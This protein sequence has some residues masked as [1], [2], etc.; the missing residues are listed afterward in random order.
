MSAQAHQFGTAPLGH[1]DGLA[2]QGTGLF[3]RHRRHLPRRTRHHDHVTADLAPGGRRGQFDRGD[4]KRIKQ[5]VEAFLEQLQGTAR[6]MTEAFIELGVVLQFQ[7]MQDKGEVIVGDRLVEARHMQGQATGAWETGLG[8]QQM[9]KQCAGAPFGHQLQGPRQGLQEVFALGTPGNQWRLYAHDTGAI[10]RRRHAYAFDIQQV[11]GQHRNQAFLF[12]HDAGETAVKLRVVA[13][14]EGELDADQ[15]TGAAHLADERRITLRQRLQLLQQIGTIVPDAVQ[16]LGL[17]AQQVQYFQ[18]DTAGQG[19]A[20]KGRGVFVLEVFAVGVVSQQ[21]GTDRHDPAAQGL[22][23]QQAVGLHP[24]AGKELAGAPEPGLHF[25]D[26]QQCAV[27]ITGRANS[28]EVIDW[29]QVDAALALDRLDDNGG[30]GSRVALQLRL[31]GLDVAVIDKVETRQ[32]RLETFLVLIRTGGG[33]RTQGLA[34]KAL[35]GRQDAL[36]TGLHQAGFQR[37]LDGFSTAVL[38]SHATVLARRQF[39]Q[40]LGQQTTGGQARRLDEDRL[41]ALLEARQFRQQRVRAMTERQRTI[42][43]EEIQIGLPR[44]VIEIAALTTDKGLVEPDPADQLADGRVDMLFEGTDFL[45]AAHEGFSV[46]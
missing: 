40:A 23:Q 35:M 1:V 27:A 38:E 44:R 7:R 19:V 24:F 22:G 14:V 34:V 31:D 12:A 11:A 30:I 3:H 20:A 2:D 41:A 39:Q 25:V 18:A 10:E 33:Q 32:W 13:T 17:V 15:V 16:Q 28:L 42:G 46:G 4:E 29:R 26:D 8:L 5:R 36:A 21:A 45:P 9:R 6:V 43:A 37:R